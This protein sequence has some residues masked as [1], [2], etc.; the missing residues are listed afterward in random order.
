MIT[1]PGLILIDDNAEELELIHQ[2]FVTSGYP[3]LPVKYE[4]SD[5]DNDSGIDHVN[6]TRLTPRIIITDLNLQE[7]QRIEPTNLVGPIAKLLRKLN[8]IGPYILFFWSKNENLVKDVMGLLEQRDSFNDI[9][10]PLYHG[11][12]NKTE[13]IGKPKELKDKV[14]NIIKSSPIF[15]AL[16]DW[17]N[18][19][20]KAAIDTTNLLYILTKPKNR[21]DYQNS[22]SIRLGNILAAIGNETLGDKNAKDHTSAALDLGLAPVLNDRLMVMQSDRSIWESAIPNI[23]QKIDLE[24][25]QKYTLNS[26]Y[27]VEDIADDYPKNRKGVFIK[28]SEAILLD[29]DNRAKLERKLGRKIK[30][31]KMDE[32]LSGRKLDGK[33]K[34]EMRT[35]REEA[36]NSIELGFVELSADCDQAQ[37]KVRLHKYVLSALIPI[38]YQDITIFEFNDIQRPQSHE[39]IYRAPVIK[40]GSQAYILKLSFKYQI[41]TIPFC[42]LDGNEYINKWLGVPKFR[43]KE[44]IL[45]DISFK[46]AQYSTRPG[47]ISFH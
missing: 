36:L 38:E 16:F 34:A 4:N 1:L 14:Q 24:E 30:D 18:R 43:L 37:R 28:I 42:N 5:A 44:Q 31:I 32:F 27:H 19:I 35:Y 46:C 12:I 20:A 7:L 6:L 40:I 10:L 8:L 11:V 9:Q 45:G 33:S 25:D 26:F 3:C 29:A 13:F 39:G 2:S 22:H 47:I 21:L 41:G 15:Y 23:G 17:E